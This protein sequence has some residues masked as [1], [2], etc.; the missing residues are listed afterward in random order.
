VFVRN[1]K[2][3]HKHGTIML[4]TEGM[5]SSHRSAQLTPAFRHSAIEY[6][7][8][9]ALITRHQRSASGARRFTLVRL[10]IGA[11][12]YQKTQNEFQGVCLDGSCYQK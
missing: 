5:P 10:I 8:S 7:E 4:R 2:S 11:A 9:S 1:R 3:T 12:N 6:E